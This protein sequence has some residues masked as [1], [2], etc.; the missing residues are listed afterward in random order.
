MHASA[1]P[2]QGD[3]PFVESPDMNMRRFPKDVVARQVKIEVFRPFLS[4]NQEAITAPRVQP[5]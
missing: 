5:K 3:E 4:A 1:P 2:F